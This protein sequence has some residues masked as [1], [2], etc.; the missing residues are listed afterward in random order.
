MKNIKKYI[1]VICLLLLAGSGY[2]QQGTIRIIA[3]DNVDIASVN[4]DQLSRL[5][6]KK[7]TKWDNGVKVTPVDLAADSDVRQNFTQN[8]HKKSISAINAY[9][10]KKIFTG[11]GVPP[12]ELQSDKEVIEFVSSTPGAIGYVSASA[13]L[14][15]VKTISIK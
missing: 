11:K 1:F 3:N 6:L 7:T 15:G 12:V 8:I 9:W 13:S 5:F 4:K 14:Q 2:A 10:Q